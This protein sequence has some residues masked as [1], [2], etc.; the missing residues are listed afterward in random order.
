M[1][2]DQS[3]IGRGRS[4]GGVDGQQGS[5]DQMDGQPACQ[6]PEAGLVVS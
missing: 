1:Q 2:W 5:I 3:R 4:W 6:V